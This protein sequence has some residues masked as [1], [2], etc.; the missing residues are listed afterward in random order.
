MTQSQSR[1]TRILSPTKMASSEKES[2]QKENEA[3]AMR[4]RDIF[5]RLR[6]TRRVS[7]SPIAA[8]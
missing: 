1:R 4:C 7:A 6:Y 5:E 8:N 3:L 2:H